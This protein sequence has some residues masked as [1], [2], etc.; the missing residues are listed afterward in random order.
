[1]TFLWFRLARR[2]DAILGWSSVYAD[3]IRLRCEHSKNKRGR[4]LP[5]VGEL[6]EVI[7]RTRDARRLDCPFVFH[8]DGKAIGDFRGSRRPACKIAGLGAVR[9]HDLRVR[10]RVTSSARGAGEHRDAVHRPQDVV[11]LRPLWHRNKDD[12]AQASEQLARLLAQQPASGDDG[13]AAQS[14]LI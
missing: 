2:R 6:A 5:L 4:E 13:A 8:R 14:R 3:A 9:I 10:R 7:R 12:L 1:M 11:D